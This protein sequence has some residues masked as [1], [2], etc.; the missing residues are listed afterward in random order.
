M[1]RVLAREAHRGSGTGR[2]AVVSTGVGSGEGKCGIRTGADRGIPPRVGAREGDGGTIT[3]RDPVV[4]GGTMAA[5][6]EAERVAH[7]HGKAVES[8]VQRLAVRSEDRGDAVGGGV[9]TE[10]DRI[11]AGEAEG[12]DAADGGEGIVDDLALSRD[13]EGVVTTAG[14]DL[15]ASEGRLCKGAVT[16][17]AEDT[18]DTDRTRAGVE[19]DRAGSRERQGLEVADVREVRIGNRGRNPDLQGVGSGSA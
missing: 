9:R 7:D 5:T 18:L 12:L 13:D 4:A 10:G 19:G 14:I 3:R 16:V 6:G 11:V 8:R 15:E 2:D 1:A 17:A